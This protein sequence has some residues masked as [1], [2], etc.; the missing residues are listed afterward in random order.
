MI[1]NV[2]PLLSGR[3]QTRAL[4]RAVLLSVTAVLFGVFQTFVINYA[5]AQSTATRPTA[6]G[7]HRLE[8]FGGYSY[9]HFD[10]GLPAH[11]PLFGVTTTSMGMNGWTIAGTYNVTNYLGATAEF[12]GQYVGDFFGLNHTFPGQ[13]TRTH[14]HNFLFGPTLTYRKN[15]KIAPFARILLGDSHATILNEGFASSLTRDALALAAG[16]GVDYKV[17][18]RLAVRLAQFDYIHSNFDYRNDFVNFSGFSTSQNHFRYSAGIVIK[19]F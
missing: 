12:S 19:A 8:A 18:N 10:S 1:P 7:S 3:P 15:T 9:L 2:E 16:G 5:A 17:G 6:P 4:L 13:P 11:V 14:V